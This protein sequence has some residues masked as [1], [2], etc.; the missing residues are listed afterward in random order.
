MSSKSSSAI[1]IHVHTKC[2]DRSMHMYRI[3]RPT[4]IVLLAGIAL[5]ITMSGTCLPAI[6][7]NDWK[8]APEPFKDGYLM[9]VFGT[10]VE[11]LTIADS[12]RSRFNNS[13]GNIANPPLEHWARC[14]TTKDL[15]YPQLRAMVEKYLADNPNRWDSPMARI[16]WLAMIPKCKEQ[17]SDQ[18]ER[19]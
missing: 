10:W 13:E 5:T 16:A 19:P 3:N 14:I 7:G 6:T 15:P 17:G 2:G 1:Y 11:D 12:Y 8:N 18:S 4:F 9:G